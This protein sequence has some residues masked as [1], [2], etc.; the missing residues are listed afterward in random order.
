MAIR[1]PIGGEFFDKII[2]NG[3]Y[4][5]DKTELIYELLTQDDVSVALFTR[6]RR[7]GKT[8][9]ITMLQSFLDITQD[10]RE[11]FKGLSVS[12]HE[13]FCDDWMNRYPVVFLTLKDVEGLSYDS[14]YSSLE[15]LIARSFGDYFR[16]ENDE[17]ITP[18]DR[19][20]F[21]NLIYRCAS[22][23]EIKNSLRTISNVLKAVYE[24]PVV[25]LI[26]EYDVPLAKAR[27]NGYY[28]QML[29]LMRR[30]LSSG[31]KTNNNMAKAILTGCLRISKESIFTG[32]NNFASF[33]VLDKSFSN[34]FGFTYDEVSALLHAAERDDHLQ[35][36]KEWYDGYIFG[37]TPVY[38]PWDAVQYVA[39]IIK[40]PNDKP[41]NYWKNSSGNGIIREFV[42]DDNFNVNDKFETLLNGGTI[43]QKISDE[44]TYDKLKFSEDNLWS[45]L[46]MTG[47][48][49]KADPEEDGNTVS[50]RIPNAEI[51]TIFEETVV[52]WF[53]ETLDTER[54]YSLMNA[55][56]NGDEAA[57]SEI[58]SDMLF[59]TIS[60]LDYHEDYYHAFLAGVFVG[61]GYGVESNKEKGLGRPDIFL[62]D[63]KNRR[64]MLIK[65]K[66]SRSE[67]RMEQDCR[68]A[69]AQIDE[70]QYARRL[71]GYR[72]VMRY[73]VAF[74]EKQ[75]L[76]KKSE[77]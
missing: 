57:A 68:E 74:F 18:E 5:I 77:E 37:N 17:R 56:W 19:E 75:A 71:K 72:Q 39:N 29:D 9:T 15:S 58:F 69:L 66:K 23:D 49:T 52:S 46:V 26:D 61:R 27:E 35:I 70:Q 44:L 13:Q 24:K 51:A 1:I 7:F 43:T 10:S 60:Y 59:D 53:S 50:L 36:M 64:A 55:L 14:A 62:T 8:L 63:R 20:A 3:S 42:E 32:V 2:K 41:K 38:C 16:L 73:G 31:L 11:L 6:P 33:S 4:Y 54:L 21:H 28:P 40:F 47:Y 45:V 67:E 76:V 30:F 12:K 65:A 25:L 48:L 22:S 34:Y